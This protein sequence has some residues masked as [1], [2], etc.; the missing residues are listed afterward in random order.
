VHCEVLKISTELTWWLKE[1]SH[2][3]NGVAQCQIQKKWGEG[4]QRAVSGRGD[5]RR[6]EDYREREV[7]CSMAAASHFGR[8]HKG[9][10]RL[11]ECH[12]RH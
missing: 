3:Y 6:N 2:P 11:A 12:E 4:V 1:R 5:V 9:L 10:K 8:L 7:C